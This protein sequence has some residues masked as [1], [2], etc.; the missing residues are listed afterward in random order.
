MPPPVKAGKSSIWD[1]FEANADKLPTKEE[2]IWSRTGCY[3][4]QETYA[5]ACS[6]A[7]LFL[8]LG[9]TPNQLVA[10]YLNNSPE[11]MFAWAATWAIGTAP[12][13]I[14][15]NLGG[16][17]LIHCLKLSDSKVVLVDGENELRSRVEEIRE[18]IEGELGMKIIVLDDELKAK[19][20]GIAP[21]R[22]DPELRRN[23]K[24]TDPVML[25]FTRYG[26]N[27]LPFSKRRS[28]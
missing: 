18:R 10:F 24:G 13:M 28:H 15:H 22:P 20:A 2:C 9:V 26:E 25:I 3:T 23:I 16:D 6:Y 8:S 1:L 5:Q 4:W 21:K 12:A 14:N 17:A 11:F 27:L 19:I 7:E